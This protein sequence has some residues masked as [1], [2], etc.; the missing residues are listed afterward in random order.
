[1]ATV[2]LL[3][4]RYAAAGQ[5]TQRLVEAV[6]AGCL[7]LT[8][9]SIRGAGRCTPPALHVADGAATATMVACLKDIA[10]TDEHVE[11]LTACLRSL[12]VFRVSRQ[13]DVL[14]D[15]LATQPARPMVAS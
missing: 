10:G 8:P 9:T 2:L 11:L 14:D 5:M 4:D 12:E 6:L 13:L 3:P 15:V 1:M 7:P